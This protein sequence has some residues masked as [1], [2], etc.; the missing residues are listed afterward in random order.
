VFAI[1][2]ATGQERPINGWDFW[3]VPTADGKQVALATFRS[4][5][6]GSDRATG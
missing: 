2:Q 5:K 3:R 4:A 1:K 6:A